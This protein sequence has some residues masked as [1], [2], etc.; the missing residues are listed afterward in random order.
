MARRNGAR[1]KFFRLPVAHEVYSARRSSGFTLIELLVVIAIIAILAAMLLPALAKAKDRAKTAQCSNNMR[2][3]GIAAQIYVTDFNDTLC[4]FGDVLGTPTKVWSEYLAPYVSQQSATNSS[5]FTNSLSF[6]SDLRKCPSGT[7]GPVPNGSFP[8]QGVWNCWVGVNFA[9]SEPPANPVTA[10]F[11]Y[12][13]GVR[14][15]QIRRPSTA[16]GFLDTAQEFVYSINDPQYYVTMP[17]PGDTINGTSG[18]IPSVQPYN[19]ARPKIHNNGCNVGF[20]DAHVERVQ[21]KVL[22]PT[23]SHHIPLCP[24]WKMQ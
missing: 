15:V 13:T 7:A 16:L 17:E 22:W 19:F 11:H 12:V 23:D 5:S 10:P 18:S 9:F 24:F 4:P 14:M 1:M 6:T 21:F 3:W 2:Q 20:L 8:A